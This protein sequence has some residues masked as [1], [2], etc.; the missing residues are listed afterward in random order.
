MHRQAKYTKVFHVRSARYR[1][2]GV[3]LSENERAEIVSQLLGTLPL[4][5]YDV[6]DDEVAERRRQL[7]SG[8]V[9]EITFDQLK[10]GLER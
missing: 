7:E 4:P 10:A 5:A 6:S 3:Q 9:E 8:E 2:Y 1:I